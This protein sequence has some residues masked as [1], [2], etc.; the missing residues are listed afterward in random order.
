MRLN[1]NTKIYFVRRG[2]ARAIPNLLDRRV[3]QVTDGERFRNVILTTER[4]RKF[5]VAPD[6]MRNV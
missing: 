1:N 5:Q 3:A 4:N 6:A 2:S